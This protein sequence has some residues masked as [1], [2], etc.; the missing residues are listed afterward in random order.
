MLIGTGQLWDKPEDDTVGAKT[1]TSFRR[2]LWQACGRNG[3][4][5]LRNLVLIAVNI[6]LFSIICIMRILSLYDRHL[7]TRQ[8]ISSF[9][10]E[11]PPVG[12]RADLDLL[13]EMVAQGG[14][15]AE[16]GGGSDLLDGGLGRLE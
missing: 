13:A 6:L 5:L 11:L 16:A 14:G 8:L 1:L 10:P 12:R 9:H 7:G 2:F 3:R 15:G 4:Q